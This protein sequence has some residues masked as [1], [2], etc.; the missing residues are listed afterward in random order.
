MKDTNTLDLHL[1]RNLM[2]LFTSGLLFWSSLTSMLPTLPIYIAST[3]ATKLQI[4][5]IMG[6][7]AVG[8]FLF[9]P[10]CG[11]LADRRGRKIVLL[12]GMSVAAIAPI[13]Y[14][15][16][17]S[18]ILLMLVRAFHGISIAAFS[19]GYTA[20]AADLAPENRRGEVM[21]YMTLVAPIGAAIGPAVGGYLQT[22]FGNNTFFLT[23]TVLGCLGFI[24]LFPLVNPPLV[25]RPK[26]EVPIEFWE[27]IFSRRVR[28]PALVLSILGLAMGAMDIFV[29][30]FIKST[31]VDLNVGLFF[32]TAALASFAVRIFAGSASD[33]YGRGLVMTI[34]LVLYMMDMLCVWL[35]NSS[36]SFLFA[37][38]IQGTAGGLVFPTVSAMMTDRAQNYERG[39]IFSLSF[40]G[41]DIGLMG[42]GPFL[43]LV[44]EHIGYRNMYGCGVVLC[45]LATLTFITQSNRNLAESLRFAFGLG[46]DAYMVK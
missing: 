26:N 19:T 37:A 3:G 16:T 25:L 30:L 11:T 33:K 23:A 13:F 35:A 38:F 45:C 34:G 15:F 4:G 39:R 12:M 43:G 28:I 20:L 5:I 32:T 8:M 27:L 42:S 6:S 17:K 1:R 14:L 36:S 10:Q 21:G 24:C 29:S 7:F 41:F 18:M 9:R 40:M 22:A 46:E 2:L 44:A 31:G